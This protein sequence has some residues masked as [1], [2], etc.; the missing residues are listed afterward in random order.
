MQ[1]R[2][3]SKVAV[4]WAISF[5]MVASA[6]IADGD[7]TPDNTATG[8]DATIT[9]SATP[10]V[11]AT[12][13]G[14][15]TRRK[16]GPL[17]MDGLPELS[18]HLAEELSP[19]MAIRSAGFRGW[20]PSGQGILISTRFGET[21]QV[22]WVRD[23]LGARQQLTFFNE[24]VGGVAAS[25]SAD[26]NGFLFTKDVGGGESFQVFYYDLAKGT[27]R[28]L[29][30]GKARHGGPLW[31]PD[32]E[33]FAYFTTRRN[34]KDW[35]IITGT[36]AQG[37]ER[38]ILRGEG[39]WIPMDFS[40]R[41][42]R[43]IVSRLVSANESHPHLLD[44]ETGKTEPFLPRD[45]KVSFGRLRFSA[46][47][48]GIYFT[49]DADSE[50][51]RLRHY[52]LEGGRETVLS[53]DLDWDV[54]NFSL[55]PDGRLLAY[56]VNADGSSQLH[57]K[58][59]SGAAPKIAELPLGRVNGLSFSADGRHLGFQLN[60][61]R[62]PGDV[63]SLDLESGEMTRWTHSEI[64]GLDQESFVLPKLVRY[65]TFDEVDGAPR[66]IPAFYY[67]PRG[68]GPFPVVVRIHGG[69]EGQSRPTFDALMQY[70]INELGIAVLV[71][72]V[73]GSSGYGKSYLQLDNGKLREDSVADIG[74]LLD[75]I[76]TRPEL[77][78]ERVAVAGGS[79]GGYMVLASLVH[80]SERLRAAIDVVGISNFVTFLE[81][82]KDYR[83]DLRRV[84]YGDE[85][86]P[87]M[88]A[89][90]EKISPANHADRMNSPLF[91]VQGLNDPRVPVTESEQMLAELRRQ[92]KEVW[93]LM[94]EDEGHG[95]R[96]QGNRA[97]YNQAVVLFLQRYLLSNSVAEKPVAGA[98]TATAP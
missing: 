5:G 54:E 42:D 27:S 66:Q 95:F 44:L 96:K 84:E 3:W 48:S 12:R 70:W 89:F 28:L 24:P 58:A 23:P 17:V 65:P 9:H 34:G 80:Y 13:R 67:R 14:E 93:Y 4:S 41:R 35:D 69:P 62:S 92:D 32:G 72:N 91:I 37:E 52:D 98:A 8:E 74:S 51:Q 53:G 30:D 97:V 90:L 25:P 63:F 33:R 6:V 83:R 68:D 81:N 18:P 56:V 78:A 75:W 19:Y 64:G 50:F 59:L 2:T 61:P 29:S 57:L 38:T 1:E 40:P 86:V 21:S 49:S 43:L 94:A 45:E 71:P 7:T 87:D 36:P 11:A 60:S 31:S 85:R 10:E 77:D 20:H 82:T 76:A 79:Y 73:R 39:A 46:D 47:G 26:T 88:R 22:H 55:S 15:P 16:V